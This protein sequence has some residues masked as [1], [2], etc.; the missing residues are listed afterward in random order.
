M[1]GIAGILGA[2][3]IE[4]PMLAAMAGAIAHRGPDDDG[5]WSDAAAGIGLAH[6]RLAI[7]DLSPAG[8]QPMDSDGGRHMLVFNGEIYNHQ[9]LRARLGERSW[10]GHS[11]TETLLAA[12][13]QWGLEAA[14][15]AAVG[16]FAIALWDRREQALFLARDRMGEKPL[17]Y[18]WADGRFLFASELKSLTALPGFAP[19]IDRHSVDRMLRRAYV[20][21]PGCI[22]EGMHKLLPGALLRIEPGAAAARPRDFDG[23]PSDFPGLTLR[24]FWSMEDA[25][26]QGA[27]APVLNLAE[28]ADGLEAVLAEAVAGQSIADVPLGSFLSGGVDSSA[29]T[30]L[31]QRHGGGRTETFTIGFDEAGF[32]EAPF[33]RAVAEHLGTRHHET[34]VGA[35]DALDLIPALPRMYDEPFADSSQIPTHLL[36]K[37][38][39]Q[40]VT[41]ALSGDGGDELF[42]GY[43]RFQAFPALRQR[44]LRLPAPVRAMAAAAIDGAGPERLA[45]IVRALGLDGRV[46]QAGPRA[47]R[48]SSL[49][50]HGGSLPSFYA[51]SMTTWPLGVGLVHG[52]SADSAWP[53]EERNGALDEARQLM[54]WDAAGYLTDDILCKVDRASMAVSLETRA[55]FLDH[56]VVEYAARIPTALHF[57]PDG[58]KQVLR[59]LLYRHVPRALIDRPKAGFSIPLDAWL[60]GPLRD[61]AEDLLSP[62][63]LAQDGLLRPE[64]ITRHWQ[65]HLADRRDYASALWPVLMLQAWRSEWISRS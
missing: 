14:L 65:A 45:G 3:P 59:H 32:D 44:L 42:G 7:L 46:P 16:M 60:R 63:K 55:P 9:S 17:Y 49:L 57:G 30:A 1:C 8:H 15:E 31:L 64:P 35:R 25:L 23:R 10:R 47:A 52:V 61:W 6:R 12:I 20:P 18:G 54:A 39:R 37:V 4:P 56:R 5:Q 22:Y 28:A 40:R 19:R 38:A 41:V 21:A 27:T 26:E 2:T 34:R 50:R 33:A 62:A 11:D 51:A 36:C 53:G 58:G 13:E 29:I 48:L 24:R 43:A